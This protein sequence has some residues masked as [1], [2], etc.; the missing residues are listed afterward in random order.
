MQQNQ[1][2]HLWL[3]L[4]PILLVMA[5]ITIPWLNR[6]II[7]FDE[8][9]SLLRAGAGHFPAHSLFEV[10]YLSIRYTWAPL[11]FV[12][13][14]I[15]DFLLQ[16]DSQFIARSLQL[17]TAIISISLMFRIGSSIFDKKAGLIAAFIL[18]TNVMF[19]FYV[20]EMRPYILWVLLTTL[21]AWLYWLLITSDSPTRPLKWA[22]TITVAATLYT[23]QLSLIFVAALGLFH[24]LS[25]RRLGKDKWNQ[26]FFLFVLAGLLY[27]P[28]L[29]VVITDVM[30]ESDMLR[31]VNRPQLLSFGLFL[32][33]NGLQIFVLLLLGYVLQWIKEF[34]VRYILFL[35]LIPSAIIIV[36]DIWLT[37]LFHPRYFMFALPFMA[38]LLAYALTKLSEQKS[39]ILVFGFLLIWLVA[40]IH[41]TDSNTPYDVPEDP[42]MNNSAIAISTAAM[43]QIETV[44]NS[45]MQENDMLALAV[46]PAHE[47][48]IWINPFAYYLVSYD[49]HFGLVGNLVDIVPGPE[50]RVN[51]LVANFSVDERMNLMTDRRETMWL[52]SDPN[53]LL[54]DE[55]KTFRDG[56][57]QRNYVECGAVIEEHN[58][59]GTVWTQ[60]PEQCQELLSTCSIVPQQ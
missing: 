48:D 19:I 53:I 44:A 56:L 3:W 4:I 23:H 42:S 14:A 20:H 49:I 11:Y 32:Y 35:T 46:T 29:G 39:N 17:F 47:D 59:L 58:L 5:W 36:M 25:F 51:E 28:W 30:R 55:L 41:Y 18:A 12:I 21:S 52:M 54:Y 15:W 60:N 45:C 26:I 57:I 22:F 9:R 38:L 7:W 40:G 16:G 6:D 13:L 24:I 33:S 27:S 2:R 43:K 10:V 8:Y 1:D 34:R 37:F 50:I 31:P